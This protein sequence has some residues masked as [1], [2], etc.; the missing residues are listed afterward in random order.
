MTQLHLWPLLKPVCLRVLRTE[1]G[2]SPNC[3]Q[4]LQLCWVLIPLVFS[5]TLPISPLLSAPLFTESFLLALTFAYIFPILKKTFLPHSACPF[6][7]T[8]FLFSHPQANFSKQS[9]NVLF[10]F[11]FLSISEIT[12]I[13]VTNNFHVTKSKGHFL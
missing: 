10:F 11:T 2:F 7:H 6:I 4:P 3:G 8:T 13:K 9:P 12:L 1:A 5:G